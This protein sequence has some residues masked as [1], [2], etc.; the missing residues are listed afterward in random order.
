[1]EQILLTAKIAVDS[2][3]AH[4]GFAHQIAHGNNVETSLPERIER[5]VQQVFAGLRFRSWHF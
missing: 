1:M 5:T 2:S 3:S 4:A